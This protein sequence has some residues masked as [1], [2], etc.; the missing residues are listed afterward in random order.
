MYPALDLRKPRR[1]SQLKIQKIVLYDNSSD[2]VIFTESITWSYAFSPFKGKMEVNNYKMHLL[3]N[4]N[5]FSF[6]HE[7][8]L[9]K[10]ILPVLEV[11]SSQPAFS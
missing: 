6:N 5:I 7:K 2:K 1:I 11:S 9:F 3:K 10:L 4:C 8:N